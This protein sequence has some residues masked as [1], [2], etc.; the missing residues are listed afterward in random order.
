MSDTEQQFGSV[1]RELVSSLDESFF[2]GAG[3][4]HGGPPATLIDQESQD[5]VHWE[6]LDRIRGLVENGRAVEDKNPSQAAQCWHEAGRLLDRRAGRSGE[7]WLCHSAALAASSEFTPA[8]HSL[9]RLARRAGDGDALFDILSRHVDNSTYPLET[10]SLLSEKGAL[11]IRAERANEAIDSLRESAAAHDGSLTAQLLKLGV[12]ARENDE[13]ELAE[14]I[15]ALADAWIEPEGAAGASL[16]LVLLE[17][18]LGRTAEALDRLR[19]MERDGGLAAPALLAKIRLCLRSGEHA[20]AVGALDSLRSAIDDPTTR[21][22]L[23]RARATVATLTVDEPIDTP[24]DEDEA[25]ELCW[26]PNLLGALEQGD[27][28]AEARSLDVA[29]RTC[30]TPALVAASLGSA[31]L[32]ARNG[33]QG[34]ETVPPQVADAGPFAEALTAFLGVGGDR[35]SW[36]PG[37]DRDT[38]PVAVLHHALSHDEHQ[39]I[40]ESL[41]E[42]RERAIDADERWDLAVAEAAVIR[43]RLSDPERALEVLRGAAD[44]LDR[45]PLPSLIRLHDRSAPSLAELALAEAASAEDPQTE[46]QL[47]AWAGHHLKDTDPDE[48][49]GL[50]RRALELNPTCRLSLAALERHSTEHATLAASFAAAASAA[51]SSEEGAR[52]LVRAGVHHLATG[53]LD[54]A[55]VHFGDALELLPADNDLWR[56]V[57]RLATS[58]EPRARREFMDSPPFADEI[59]IEDLL[60]LGNLGLSVDPQAAARWFE[61]ALEVSPDDPA[62]QIGLT[63]ALLSAGRWSMVSG[64]LLDELREAGTDEEEALVYARMADIDARYGSDPSSALLS[65][66]SLEEKLPGHRP[67]LAKL[68]FYFTRQKRYEELVDVLASLASTLDDDADAAAFA[69]AAWQMSKLDLAV[70]R[71]AV[72]RDPSAL[73]ELVELESRT[74]DADERKEL[75]GRIVEQLEHSPVFGSRLADAHEAAGDNQ[76]ALELRA[77]IHEARPDSLLELHG[78]ERAQRALGDAQGAVDTLTRHAN[79]TRIPDL[80]IESLLQAAQLTRAQVG[81]PGRATALCLS[82][83]ETDPASDQAYEMGRDLVEQTGDLGMLDQLVSQRISGVDEPASKHA[84][85]LE[86]ADIRLRRNDREG[87]KIAYGLALELYPDDRQTHQ[88][89]AYLHR[90]DGEWDEAIEHLMEAARLA[91]EPEFGIEIFFAL[92]ELYMDHSERKDL[93][94]KSFV[95]VLGWNRQHF[96]AMDR[97]A[98]L[99]GQLGNWSR[100]AQALERLVLMAEDPAIKISKMVALAGALETKLNRAKDAENLLGEARRIDPSSIVPV[101]ALASMYARQRDSMALNVLLDQALSNQ[102]AALDANPDDASLLGNIM[103]LLTMKADDKVASLAAAAI[104]LVGGTPPVRADMNANPPEASW[105]VAGRAGDPA[106]EDFI[107]PKEAPA[108]LRGMLRAVE[109]PVARLLGATAKQMS[110]PRDARLDRKHPLCQTV[111]QLAQA[112]GLRQEPTLY[113]GSGADLTVAPGS[114]PSVLVPKSA[115][116]LTHEGELA[117]VAS[118]ALVLCRSGLALATLLPEERLRAMLAALVK[119]S[120]PSAATP[121]DIRAE[122]IEREAA[123]L[124]EAVPESAIAQIQPLAFDCNAALEHPNVGQ[125]ILTIAH[126]AGFVSA[127]SLTSA[128]AGLRAIGGQPAG[129]LAQLPGA[130]RLLAFVFSKDHLEVRQRMGL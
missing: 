129:P 41:A 70:L 22:A 25:P 34:I 95:K 113:V 54:E 79:A 99:Y 103:I 104:R 53:R 123:A 73:L 49:S 67:T 111:S 81:S 46:S 63:E 50:H 64:R 39:Q 28:E 13:L 15:R 116:T 38:D 88:T 77:R 130:G 124:R 60:A 58:D 9:R 21:G 108:G 11:E 121:P 57:I 2:E 4:P 43:N 45:A 71:Q 84:L 18:R 83:L 8:R 56:S 120:I 126:R 76:T 30:Q 59:E 86:L 98:T 91:R 128:I 72:S 69:T 65:L 16:I 90:E 40:A 32:A 87:A 48:S 107:S 17:E 44:Q 29:A 61:K 78:L 82:V 89:L 52:N 118:T 12:A 96:P 35:S 14:S 93:A 33:G 68:L 24:G 23:S 127:G 66:L 1:L 100:A 119:L 85:L 74:A 117:F 42:M 10:S 75:L 94:E 5:E 36:A 112:F 20:E 110:L 37:F 62:G 101:E 122:D 6:L 3:A 19:S 31:T 47:L 80:R 97:L 51:G 27:R 106:L 102:S 26:A 125:S 105:H 109:E 92:G 114:P 7:A 115:T 55:L